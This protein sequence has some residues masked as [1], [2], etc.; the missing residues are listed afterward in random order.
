MNSITFTRK[1]NPKNNQEHSHFPMERSIPLKRVF[2]I[3]HFNSKQT[4]KLFNGGVHCR[5][6]ELYH[7][8]I[9]YFSAS[10]HIA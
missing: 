3:D 5:S 2:G 6:S 10:F 8:Y 9:D 7:F 4:N 1:N